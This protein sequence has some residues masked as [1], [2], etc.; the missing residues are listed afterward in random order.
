M[1][2]TSCA[3]AA[4]RRAD[5]ADLVGE[6]DLERVEGVGRRTSPSRPSGSSS[7]T[8]GASTPAY[9]ARTV[10]HGRIVGRADQRQ[11]RLREVAQRRALAHELRVDRERR[12]SPRAR[13]PRRGRARAPGAVPSCRAGRCCAAPRCSDRAPPQRAPDLLAHALERARCRA[14]RCRGPASR[15]RSA[16]G[17][18]PA[19]PPRVERVARSRPA[20]TTSAISSPRPGSTIGRARRVDHLDLLGVDVDA[21]HLVPRLGEAGAVTQPT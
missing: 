10:G 2:I 21:D 8:N 9:S 14:G 18:S 16:R 15:R 20:A 3:S 1:R 6:A 11:R 7:W 12:A 19:R 17:R 4:E 13:A 5:V